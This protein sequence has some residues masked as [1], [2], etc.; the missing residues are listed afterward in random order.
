MS[1]DIPDAKA[2]KETL[3]ELNPEALMY[4][5]FDAALVGIIARCSTEPLALYDRTKCIQILVDEGASHEEAED[6]FCYN[7]E[8]CWAGPNTPF[9]AS[10]NLDPIGVRYPMDGLQIIT[11]EG[12]DTEILFPGPSGGDGEVESTDIGSGIV[13]EA[14]E[15]GDPIG[16]DGSDEKSA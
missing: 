13:D 4:D 15:S 11:E 7:V 12:A 10:F 1:I 8:G 2:I 5:G 16:S 6:Y 14:S 9:I 3:E